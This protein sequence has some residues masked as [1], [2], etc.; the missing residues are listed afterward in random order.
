MNIKGI[1]LI[2]ALIGSVLLGVLVLTVAGV[3]NYFSRE[4]QSLAQKL[5][6]IHIQESL[7]GTLNTSAVCG[8]NLDSAKNTTNTT[9]LRFNSANL[10]NAKINLNRIF[11]SCNGNVPANPILT[12]GQAP[13]GSQ[14]GVRVSEIS[15]GNIQPTGT[16]G[17]FYG[18]LTVNFDSASMVMGRRP[19][20]VGINFLA[21]TTTPLQARITNCSTGDPNAVL[22]GN[23]NA[24]GT[25]GS[26][27]G[28]GNLGV[29]FSRYIA[30]NN[31][32]R[33]CC[34]LG[35]HYANPT[36]PQFNG[37]ALNCVPY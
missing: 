7:F 1:A 11:A 19:A 17:A 9:T 18:E 15:L 26:N 36:D 24:L 12:V 25:P 21:D 23:I 28:A 27:C 3:T 5:E 14:A 32:Q 2:P 20:I 29:T 13:S 16:P 34:T 4:T 30:A 6:I 33:V 10:A 37:H 22:G 31:I 35:A 8:C